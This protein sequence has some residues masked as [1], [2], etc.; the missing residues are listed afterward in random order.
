MV[1]VY[2]ISIWRGNHFKTSNIDVVNKYKQFQRTAIQFPIR[3]T[4]LKKEV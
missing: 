4:E 1:K 3:I 2:R